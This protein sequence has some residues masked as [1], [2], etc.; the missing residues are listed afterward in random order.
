DVTDGAVDDGTGAAAAARG[1]RKELAPEAGARGAGGRG[2]ED[3]V[4]AAGIDSLKLQLVGARGLVR[5]CCP[6]G[7]IAAANESA[8]GGQRTDGD[9]R[10]L[11]IQAQLIECVAHH[12]GIE[13]VADLREHDAS[14][15]RRPLIST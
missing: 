12:S 3:V 5:H 9:T 8:C 13:M 10:R 11:V 1:G 2:D 15:A 14:H 7:R 4:W 6:K